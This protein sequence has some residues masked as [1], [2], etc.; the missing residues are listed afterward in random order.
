VSDEAGVVG[1]LLQRGWVVAPG[2][3]YR[4]GAHPSAVRVTTATLTAEEAERLSA[5]IADVTAPAAWS[6]TG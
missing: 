4:L 2:A 3:P 6:R 1:S 5:D